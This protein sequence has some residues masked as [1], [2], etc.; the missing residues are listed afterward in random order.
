MQTFEYP[1]NAP[2]STSEIYLRVK[3]NLSLAPET[4]WLDLGTQ[5]KK[6]TGDASHFSVSTGFGIGG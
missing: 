1:V 2:N 4:N 5:K 6:L 3:L